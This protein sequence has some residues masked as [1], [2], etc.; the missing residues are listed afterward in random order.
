MALRNFEFLMLSG[1]V[2]L[3]SDDGQAVLAEF[4]EAV[5]FLENIIETSQTERRRE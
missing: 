5:R 2:S 1:E 4:R 3:E